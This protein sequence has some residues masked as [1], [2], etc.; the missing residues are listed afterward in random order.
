MVNILTKIGFSAVVI[1]AVLFQIFLQETIWLFLG[2]GRV[3]Q[4]LAD[5]PYTCRKIVD[6]RM[7][8]C[9]DMW[10]SQ[11]TR[12]MFLACSDPIARK[13]WMP[14]VGH[15]NISDAWFS[16]TFGDG[17]INVVGFTGMENSD[18]G[19]D[20]MI[21]NL[22]PSVDGE[23]GKLLDQYVSG[24]NTT[25]EHFAT[26]AEATELKHVRTYADQGIATPNRVAVLDDKTF[27]ITNDHGPHKHGWRY[28]LAMLLGSANIHF[29]EA[30]KP[31]KEVVNNLKFP[32]GLARKD[33]IIYVPDSITGTLYIYRILPNKEL[34]KIDEVKLGYGLDNASI[35]ENGDIW[36]AAFPVTAAIFQAYEDPYNA[37]TPAAVL[38]VRK[39]DGKY[40]VDKVIEDADGEVLPA[41]TTVV[42]DAKTGRLF[43]SSVISPFI[44]VCEPKV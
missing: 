5:F 22:R 2:V 31:C 18:G 44:A 15:L 41:A 28:H 24:A 40:V 29:C 8:A 38:R 39:V 9:E 13:H 32:N 35:D 37:H 23:S 21:V 11:S 42:H 26:S 12:Q 33:D 3:M 34:E 7:E 19:I 43:L 17:L 30:N 4:P 14:S 16:G 25:I 1:L 20:L 36:I 27:Y 6:P 10:L